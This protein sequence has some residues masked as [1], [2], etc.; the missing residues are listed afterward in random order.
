MREHRIDLENRSVQCEMGWFG[1]ER[2]M[3]KEC[4]SEVSENGGEKWKEVK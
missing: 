1:G 3:R 4:I 2:E